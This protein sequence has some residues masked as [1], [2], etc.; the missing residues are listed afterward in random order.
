MRLIPN[1]LT[2]LRLVIAPIVAWAIVTGRF[3]LAIAWVAFAGITDGL[4]GFTARKFNA[5]SNVGLVLDPIADKCMLVT[6]FL[7]LGYADL[8]PLWMIGLMVA[9]DLVIVIGA[10]LLRIFRGIRKFKPS[11]LGKISTFFQIAYVL[12]TLLNAA[13][14]WRFFRSLD[15]T[16]LALTAF[17]TS[18]SGAG[19]IRR[20]ILMARRIDPFPVAR[21]SSE[22]AR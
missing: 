4:D 19:Y 1:L 3:H 15:T 14:P 5:A 17:F 12:L 20:G 2:S 18:L 10:L 13:W 8:I 6:L 21:S 7:A 22:H 9:R 11:I 16:S